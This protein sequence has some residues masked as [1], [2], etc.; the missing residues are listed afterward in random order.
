M[1]ASIAIASA[2][3]GFFPDKVGKVLV[4]V[5]NNAAGE[6]K[7]YSKLTVKDVKGSSNHMT[8]SYVTEILDKDR[9][10]TSNPPVEIPLKMISKNGVM[11]MDMKGM[12]TVPQ[13]DQRI[14]MEI[15]G[16]PMEL[17]NSLEPGQL[18]KDADITM[19][20][21]MG[22]MKLK[23]TMK[24]TGGK[25]L[26]IE[27]VT[28]P[29][30]TFTCSKVTQTVSTSTVGENAAMAGQDSTSQTISW[31]AHGIGIVKTETYDDKGQLKG[32]SELV[33]MN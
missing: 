4:Y 22:I 8:I 31:Y 30:G 28:V 10:S 25:C 33:E 27:D 19:N 12:F 32:S 2:Q 16:N 14:K 7:S 26:A 17:P 18:L 13:K 29:A 24:M 23:T 1:I 5:Q 6:P 9:K 11:I 20:M 15:S 21:D 3:N